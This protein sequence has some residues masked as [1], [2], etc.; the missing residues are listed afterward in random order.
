[1]ITRTARARASYLAALPST[2]AIPDRG[3]FYVADPISSM[4]APLFPQRSPATSL[5]CDVC[6]L[7]GVPARRVAELVFWAIVGGLRSPKYEG[8]KSASGTRQSRCDVGAG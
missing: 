1:L 7:P 6:S 3:V 8:G 5:R 2:R 4:V